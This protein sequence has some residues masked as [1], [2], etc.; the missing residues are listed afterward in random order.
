MCDP[1]RKPSLTDKWH[2]LTLNFW[3]QDI[4]LDDNSTVT[5]DLMLWRGEIITLCGNMSFTS[6]KV[7]EKLE[8]EHWKCLKGAWIWFRKR[9]MNPETV[10]LVDMCKSDFV[11]LRTDKVLRT[12]CDFWHSPKGGPYPRLGT[13]V[14]VLDK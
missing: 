3:S 2:I 10:T 6:C 4:I 1:N 12:P 13:N 8:H 7:L 5:S 11:D 14:F 9:C